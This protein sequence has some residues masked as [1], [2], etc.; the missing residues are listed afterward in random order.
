[1]RVDLEGARGNLSAPVS[2]RPALSTFTFPTTLPATPG[3]VPSRQVPTF[4]PRGREGGRALRYWSRCGRRRKGRERAHSAGGPRR[5]RGAGTPRAREPVAPYPDF[6]GLAPSTHRD[7]GPTSRRETRRGRRGRTQ[8]YPRYL[9][10]AHAAEATTV[11][12]LPVLFPVAVATAAEQLTLTTIR[13]CLDLCALP[14]A[15]PAHQPARLHP[16]PRPPLRAR[17]RR[18]AL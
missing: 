3:D 5:R 4:P 11:T 14:A 16:A 17:T 1:M 7:T 2:S 8:P 9:R 12:G 10:G 6:F 18:R 13:C 15:R